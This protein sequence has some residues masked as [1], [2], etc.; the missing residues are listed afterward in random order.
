MRRTYI[1]CILRSPSAYTWRIL[2]FSL[3]YASCCLYETVR[4]ESSSGTRA[5]RVLSAVLV[6]PSCHVSLYRSFVAAHLTPPFVATSPVLSFS[7]HIFSRLV[8]CEESF[9]T[10]I[11]STVILFTL[12]VILQ[13]WLHYSIIISAPLLLFSFFVLT[14]YS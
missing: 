14:L 11:L 13:P 12:F 1:C 2:I 4:A 7:H 6:L 8:R 3:P 9:F 5:C 10:L